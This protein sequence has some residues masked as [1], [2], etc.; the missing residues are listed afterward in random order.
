MQKLA[1]ILE[2]LVKSY[3]S[4][5]GI[6]AYTV[7]ELSKSLPK[8]DMFSKAAADLVPLANR[9]L[10]TTQRYDKDN[11]FLSEETTELL[12]NLCTSE[13]A[14]FDAVQ[15]IGLLPLLVKISMYRELIMS[16]RNNGFEYEKM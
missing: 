6:F 15:K 1:S 2:L 9:L 5:V 13:T 14:A 3:D 7:G 12:D 8:S 16:I 10:M 4:M 11:I